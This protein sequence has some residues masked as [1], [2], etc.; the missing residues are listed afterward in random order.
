ML[1]SLRS[2][3]LALVAAS[4]GGGGG[5]GGTPANRMIPWMTVDTSGPTSPTSC[6]DE[7]VH[8]FLNGASGFSYFTAFDA[9]PDMSVFVTP[10]A[11]SGV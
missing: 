11:R 8:V 7:L 10:C 4:G 9:F 6:F 2:E 1:T 5:G 3:K